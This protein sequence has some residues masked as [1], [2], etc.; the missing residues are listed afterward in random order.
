MQSIDTDFNVE[1]DEIKSYIQLGNDAIRK[2]HYNEC[3]KHYSEA[4][5]L[6]KDH[7]NVPLQKEI[8]RLII[9][10]I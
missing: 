5:K 3:I 6:A 9:T 4:L 10:L 2:G 8:N 1:E 7:C